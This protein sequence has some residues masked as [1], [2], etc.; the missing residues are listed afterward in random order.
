[1]FTE[2]PVELGE[3]VETALQ[4]RFCDG[5]L[6]THQHGL[7]ISHAGHLDI[8]TEGK[9]GH[10]LKLMGQ[11]VIADI[12]FLSQHI[13]RQF[14][15][16]M[17][18]DIAGDG[19]DLLFGGAHFPLI[20]VEIVLLIQIQQGQKFNKFLMN[21][22]VAHG[23]GFLGQQKNIIEFPIDAMLQFR[24]KTE[25]GDFLMEDAQQLLI[26]IGKTGRMLGQAEL[27]DEP[28][29]GPARRILGS[30]QCIGPDAHNIEHLQ[31]VGLALQ[32]MYRIGTQCHT[33]FIKGMK[34]LE[35][36]IDV[37]GTHV[38]IKK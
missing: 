15:G 18:M 17:A 3:T 12:E 6:G 26:L 36:H 34:M 27:D 35:L 2:D 37:R 8:V 14:F 28:F 7:H 19:I 25:S 4:R 24:V 9:T 31:I 30:V 20:S 21:N 38:V 16:I 5:Y 23:V 22:Q 29:A 32:K 1:M 11:V 33:Q 13:Q 10:I